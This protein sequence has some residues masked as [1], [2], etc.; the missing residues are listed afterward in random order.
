MVHEISG[1]LADALA[2][3]ATPVR[4]F[5]R[6]DDGGWDDAALWALLDVFAAADAP[7]DV[8]IIPT[9]A[10]AVTIKGLRERRQQFGAMLG[11]HQHGLAHLNHESTGRKQEFGPSRNA[12]QQLGDIALGQRILCGELGE[13]LDPIFTPPWNRCTQQT[14]DALRRLELQ[15]LSRDCTA[16]A[17]DTTGLARLDVQLDWEKSRAPFG[18]CAT[19]LQARLTRLVS[20]FDQVG[21]M[22]HHARMA[23]ADRELLAHLL[24]LLSRHPMVRLCNMR[25]LFDSHRHD[26][27]ETNDATHAAA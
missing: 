17:L 3:R 19:S 16:I 5:F 6:D 21:I 26:T 8:A 25:S 11:L 12:G 9:E 22:L 18:F 7:V 4:I 23:H 13:L 1:E 15:G 27:G 24:R 10:D 14:V 20:E 2:L